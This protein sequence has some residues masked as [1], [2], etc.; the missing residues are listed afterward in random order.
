MTT[1]LF[2]D[3]KFHKGKKLSWLVRDSIYKARKMS[4][5]SVDAHLI[6]VKIEKQ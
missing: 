6:F 5:H 2:L 3:Y 1:L 4:H